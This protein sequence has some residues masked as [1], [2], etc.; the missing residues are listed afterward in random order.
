MK[1]KD[2]IELAILAVCMTAVTVSTIVAQRK[3]VKTTQK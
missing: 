1:T 2:K 3:L